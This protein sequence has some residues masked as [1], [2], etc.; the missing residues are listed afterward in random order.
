MRQFVFSLMVLL[1]S[2]MCSSDLQAQRK[3]VFSGGIGAS[4][5]QGDLA[6]KFPGNQLNPSFHLSYS[7]YINPYISNRIGLSFTQLEGSDA[8]ATDPSRRRRNLSFE[9]NLAELSDVV[10]LDIIPDKNFGKFYEEDLFIHP[11]VFGGV[12]LFWFDPRTQYY[13][14]WVDLRPLGTEG[15]LFEGEED[16]PGPYS[17]VQVSI[18]MGLGVTLR[19]KGNFSVSFEAS[20]SKAFTDYLDDVSGNYADPDRINQTSGFI[21]ED[22]A[23]RSKGAYKTGEVRGNPNKKD[24]YAFLRAYV[25]FYFGH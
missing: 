25:S 17:N 21:A 24:G 23:N 8:F 22:L 11:Y 5:Y 16:T 1:L 20:Y 19:V 14:Q 4:A 18:P 2:V 15:Q 12:S 7:Y 9:T 6:E 3:H 13:G 10:V